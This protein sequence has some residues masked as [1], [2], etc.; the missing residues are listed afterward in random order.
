MDP[1]PKGSPEELPKLSEGEEMLIA[2]VFVVTQ[3][4]S[5]SDTGV[6]GY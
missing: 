1:F 2:K 5:I 4:C 3:M 6:V